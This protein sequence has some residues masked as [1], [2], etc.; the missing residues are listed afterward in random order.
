MESVVRHVRSDH[1]LV[2][3]SKELFNLNYLFSHANTYLV[4]PGTFPFHKLK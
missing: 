2:L 4:K 3:W 1:Y